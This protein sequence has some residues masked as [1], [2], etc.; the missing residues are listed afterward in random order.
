MDEKRQLLTEA[1]EML[2]AVWVPVEL[3][4]AIARP[5]WIAVQK[6]QEYL[7]AAEKPEEPAEVKEDV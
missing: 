6:I 5:V 1:V 7:D 2:N 4:D 3:A